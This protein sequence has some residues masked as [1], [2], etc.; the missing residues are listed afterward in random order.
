MKTALSLPG[1]GAPLNQSRT[2]PWH[3]LLFDG[4]LCSHTRASRA[5]VDAAELSPL[6]RLLYGGSGGDVAVALLTVSRALCRY[7]EGCGVI[8]LSF[9]H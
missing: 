1:V 6:S 2:L 9:Q 8:V 7:P 3:P 5:P 4:L